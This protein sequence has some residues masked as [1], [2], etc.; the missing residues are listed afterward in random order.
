MHR[1]LRVVAFVSV[2]AAACV[3]SGPIVAAEIRAVPMKT[4]EGEP[5]SIIEIEGELQ[6][7]DEERFADVAI[8]AGARA[9]VSLNSPGGATFAG[10]EIGKA[11]RLKGF[12]T[13]VADGATC[14]SACAFIWL[15]GMPRLMAPGGRIGFHAT[16]N[17]DDLQPSSAGNAAVGAYLNQLGLPTSA[18]LY[19]TAA[20]PAD[21]QW[22]TLQ[23]AEKVGIEVKPFKT[24]DPEPTVAE[25]DRRGATP[26]MPSDGGPS[27]SQG[28][29]SGEW[30]Q[31]AS[32]ATLSEAIRV[33]VNV[34]ATGRSPTVFRYD[35]GW[36]VVVLGPFNPGTAGPFRDSLLRTASIPYDSFVSGGVHYVEA[37]WNDGAPT[38]TSPD[39]GDGALAAAEAFFA[40]CSAPA[41]KALSYL[42]RLYPDRLMYF[43]HLTTKSA[44]LED[45]ANFFARWPQRVY[46]IEPGSTTVG[47][48][49]DG[50]CLVSGRVNWRAYSPRLKKT[51]VGTAQFALVFMGDDAG[52]L[53]AESS[54][55]LNRTRYPAFSAGQ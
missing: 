9:V 35:N 18:I 39:Q 20:A 11:I 3:F 15:G 53:I 37:V 41:P 12:P 40:T 26:P 6:I 14:A 49:P 29:G 22:L 5:F 1:A 13:V 28:V 55:V 47:C 42:S 19:I 50:S 16:Y 44:V 23:D 32:R 2:L 10:I 4:D 51:S 38:A 30:I 43:G 24:D 17:K 7:G 34:R 27:P 21:M 52:Q 33:A 31:V 54:E 36:Y 46:T 25:S 8:G 45:K 48:R